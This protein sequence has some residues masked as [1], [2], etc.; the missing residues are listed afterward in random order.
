MQKVDKNHNHTPASDDSIQIINQTQ[1]SRG[2]NSKVSTS[3]KKKANTQP[4]VSGSSTVTKGSNSTAKN[5]KS[6][7]GSNM[8]ERLENS[9]NELKQSAANK[10]TKKIQ[11]KP[12]ANVVSARALRG[13]K[14]KY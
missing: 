3:Q 10:P 9:L 5:T 11:K 1:S 8:L 13:N 14:G 7:R 2:K 12:K 4:K 6:S